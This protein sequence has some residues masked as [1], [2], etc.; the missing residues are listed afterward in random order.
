[1][2]WSVWHGKK[3]ELVQFNNKNNPTKKNGQKTATV[4]KVKY[5]NGQQ[6]KEKVLNIISHQE[7]TN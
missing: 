7:N 2:P 1:M 4:P 3:K 6:A 5:T